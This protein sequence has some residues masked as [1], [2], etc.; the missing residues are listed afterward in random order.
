ML[1]LGLL[2]EQPVTTCMLILGGGVAG[3]YAVRGRPEAR[4]R[5]IGAAITLHALRAARAMG[6][7]VAVLGATEMGYP[8]YW[9]IRLS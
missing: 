3:L 6:Y 4:R 7:R 1:Y 2:D 9:K 5:G 8:L